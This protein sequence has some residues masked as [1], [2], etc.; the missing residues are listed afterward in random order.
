MH[1]MT[2]KLG[3]SAAVAAAI[4]STTTTVQANQLY[5]D[6]RYSLNSIDTNNVDNLT[7]D[8]NASRFGLKGKYDLGG[9]NNAFYH[10]QIGFDPEAA[11]NLTRRFGFIG[12]G[13]KW[14]KTLFGTIST[15]YKLA[16]FKHDPFYDTAAGLKLGGRNYGLSIRTDGFYD[17]TLSYITPTVG[18]VT[19]N[20]MVSIDDDAAD[21]H[22]YNYGV[23]WGNKKGGVNLQ[24]L[25]ENSS[26][27]AD[28]RDAVRLSGHYKTSS[29]KFYVSLENIDHETGGDTDYLYANAT[30]NVCKNTKL[31]A[32]ICSVD[33]NN[34]GDGIG[35]A[36]DGFALGVFHNLHKK[37]Q[38]Y[39]LYS[40]VDADTNT[41][42]RDVISLGIS[43]KF[44][45]GE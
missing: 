12:L 6:I 44:S 2:T 34:G 5:A 15:Q 25:D 38:L 16:G 27:A 14:G 33:D 9:G 8:N 35:T 26:T 10:I 28:R 24:L 3:L 39:A 18:G 37:T 31:V 22:S 4:L 42:D 13:G 40:T 23:K 19:G 21:E 41:S 20:V 36:G 11:D 32:S 29:F 7:F 30:F 17:N 45:I 1:K 43:Q